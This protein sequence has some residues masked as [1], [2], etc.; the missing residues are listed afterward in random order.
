[1]IKIIFHERTNVVNMFFI[2]FTNNVK[3]NNAFYE[4]ITLL[5]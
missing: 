2:G 4:S 3:V 5:I 1:M